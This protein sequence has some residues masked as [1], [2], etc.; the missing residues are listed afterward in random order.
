M[1]TPMDYMILIHTDENAYPERGTPE[2]DTYMAGWF[3]YNQRLMDGGHWIT[4]GS[5][6]QT[7]AATTIRRTANGSAVTDG[8]YMETKEQLGGYYLIRAKDLDEALALAEGVPLP[9]ASIE[10]RPIMFRPDAD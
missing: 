5:L 4:G 1:E 7:P 6:Q 3:A 10:V 2:F 8:P 9:E